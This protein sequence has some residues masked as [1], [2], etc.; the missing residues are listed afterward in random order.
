M[1]S[2]F[3]QRMS[4]LTLS[5]GLSP[6][7]AST[8]I[9]CT[10]ASPEG[11]DPA[12]YTSGYTFDASAHPIY[13]RLVRFE[14]GS[15]R[16]VPALAQSWEISPDG[17][18]Y[19]FQLRPDV[20][21]HETKDFKP[22]RPFNA[23]DVLW[24]FQRMIDP[25]HPGYELAESGYP[26]AEAMQLKTL[27]QKVEKLS[28]GS[29]R[30]TLNY[31]D[32]PF[33]S[34]LAMPFASIL[35]AEYAQ[36]LIATGQPELLNRLPIGTGSFR[37][38]RYQKD[39]Q[40]RYAAHTAHWGGAPSVERLV[41]AI[42]PDPNVRIQRL[43]RNECQIALS[44]KPEDIPLLKKDATLTLL[45]QPALI[46]THAPIN[47]RH[48]PFDDVRV[49]QAIAMAFDKQSYLNSIFDGHAQPAIGPYPPGLLGYDSSIDDWPHDPVRAQALLQEAGVKPDTPLNLY[50]STSSGPS[51]NA[52]RAAQLIQAD[53]GHIG[54]NVTIHSL[55]W[56]ELI[57]RSKAGEHDMVLMS[58]IGDNGDPDNFLTHNLS[59]A[60]AESGDN[61]AQ[62][63][64]PRFEELILAARRL[65]DESERANLYRQSQQIFHQQLPWLPL[66]HPSLFDAQ[67]KSVSGYRMSPLGI[68][69][70][71]RVRID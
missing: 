23:D 54:L 29:V 26:Y 3:A 43:R 13:D 10:E 36:Q 27:I 16:I 41:L 63:C 66:A 31:P 45:E 67:R 61:R 42:T 21:F 44:P 35:S 39:A 62:W 8:L 47:T 70:F 58:W 59:C 20:S 51:G 40:V 7:F 24:S 9:V 48:A 11:F 57:K 28:D 2:I 34:S 52:S 60:A 17:Q 64:D 30:F 12:R 22:A 6:A 49:R 4:V 55:E 68:R 33:L 53:L 69:D 5:L 32:A 37:F 46:T 25:G 14:T 71:S 38:I 1:R 50:I 56:G 65:N 19:T 18:Q 15:T